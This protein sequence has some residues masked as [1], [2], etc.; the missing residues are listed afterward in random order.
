MCGP[1]MLPEQLYWAP[2]PRYV[3]YE[4]ANLMAVGRVFWNL[5]VPGG[6]LGF[7]QQ[8]IRISIW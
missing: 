5:S 2:V 8:N 6:P 4:Q 7:V 3:M 1:S